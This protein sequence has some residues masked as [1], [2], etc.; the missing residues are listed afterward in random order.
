MF[1]LHD[2]ALFHIT[3]YTIFLLSNW[4]FLT[5]DARQDYY[6]MAAGSPLLLGIN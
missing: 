6:N 2:F 3:I 4:P 5:H 1:N